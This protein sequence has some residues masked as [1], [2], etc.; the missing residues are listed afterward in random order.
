MSFL[1]NKQFW[2]YFIPTGVVLALLFAWELGAV[3][4]PSP[5][6]PEPTDSEI[7]FSISLIILLAFS[8]GLFGWQKKYGTCQIGAKRANGIAGVIGMITLLCPACILIPLSLFGVSVSL[9]FLAPFLPLLRLIALLIALTSIKL[10]WPKKREA[11]TN[12]C[13]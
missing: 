2:A 9:L 5:P 3:P 4:L 1:T 12:R 10:L 8:A 6:R 13:S 11:P 7:L